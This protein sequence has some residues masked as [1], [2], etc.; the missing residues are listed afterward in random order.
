MARAWRI[1]Y[2]GALYHVLS[3]GNEKQDI[4]IIDDDRKLFLGT[5]GEI[6]DRFEIDIRTNLPDHEPGSAIQIDQEIRPGQ[7]M[8]F[9]GY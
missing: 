3:R 5:A 2:E 4:V 7:A 1:E 9:G 6:G 8:H